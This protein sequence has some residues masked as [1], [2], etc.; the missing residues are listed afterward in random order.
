MSTPPTPAKPEVEFMSLVAHQLSAPLAAVRWYAEMLHKGEMAKPLDATQAE[1]LSEVQGAAARMDEL[2]TDL[3]NAAHLD[4]NKITD[5]P[6]AVQ[7]ADVVATQLQ[8]LSSQIAAHKLQL[9]V[10]AQPD[11]P[12]LT[13]QLS[14]IQMI[15]Q[16]LLTN[17]IKYTP[18]GGS[19]T[20]SIRPAAAAD[21]THLKH[22]TPDQSAIVLAVTDTGH[23]IPAAAQSQL[24]TKFYRA[25]NVRALGISGSGL[26]LYIAAAAT[27]KLGGAVWFE[28]QEHKGSS[29]FVVLPQNSPT[30]AKL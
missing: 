29:F 12:T 8:P 13:V 15:V 16:N 10:Q 20:V 7:L 4:Q 24:F 30:A 2:V 25:D 9:S 23:G 26:G 14:L 17:A 11:L 5:D 3:L 28:S 1:L 27:A 21:L 22:A 18:D 6:V 19:I